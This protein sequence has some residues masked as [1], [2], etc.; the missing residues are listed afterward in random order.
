MGYVKVGMT[1]EP[2]KSH[3]GNVVPVDIGFPSIFESLPGRHCFLY[4]R[5][6]AIADLPTLTPDTHKH[7]RG[8][9]LIIA[10][11]KGLTGAAALATYGALRAGAGLTV[12]LAPTSIESTYETL[13]VEGMTHGLLDNGKGYFI[14]AGIEAARQWIDWCDAIVIGPGLGRESETIEFLT[15]LIPTLNKPMIIDADGFQPFIRRKLRFDQ[16]QAPFMITPHYGEWAQIGGF[17]AGQIR[18]HLQDL[19]AVFFKEFNGVLALKNAP[20]CTV[21]GDGLVMNSSGNPGMAT[22][23]SG[24]VFSGICG[25]FLAQG[26]APKKASMLAAFIHGLAGDESADT[27]GGIGM[28]ARDLLGT[29]RRVIDELDQAS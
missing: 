2:G 7:H 5:E 15:Q 20:T 28:I 29:V 21:F 13:I 11:S 17:E 1:L 16:I 12:T 22:A 8:K 10:G 24:D 3:C 27:K 4:T 14:P 9:V 18:L 6:D 19:L 23:G 26:L 25:T